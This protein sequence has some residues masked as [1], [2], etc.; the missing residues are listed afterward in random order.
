MAH[1]LPETFAEIAAVLLAVAQDVRAELDHAEVLAHQLPDAPGIEYR[2][3]ELRQRAAAAERA[4]K[5][6][7]DLSSHESAARALMQMPAAAPFTQ[8]GAD[9]AA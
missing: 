1:G 2:L 6:M 9:A 3:R 8:R 5:I 4:Q 7:K